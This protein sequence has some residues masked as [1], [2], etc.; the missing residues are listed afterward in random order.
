MNDTGIVKHRPFRK[1]HWVILMV[2]LFAATF[3]VDQGAWYFRTSVIPTTS[4][5]SF[6]GTTLPVLKVANWTALTSEEWDAS[7][8]QLADVGK[9]IPLPTYDPSILKKSTESLGWSSESDLNIRNAKIT[10]S[11]PYMGNYKLD[12]VEY[13]GSHLAVDIK[14]PNNTPIYSIGNGKVVK[15]SKQSS[16]FGKHI[17]ISHY[18]FPALNDAEAKETYYSSYSHLGSVNVVENQV[19][20]KGQYIGKSG[21]T[22]TATTPHLHFQID[23]TNAP[24]HPYWPFTYQESSAADLSFTEAINTGLGKEKALETTI[25]PMLYVQKYMNGF[26]NTTTYTSSNDLPPDDNDSNSSSDDS[27][28]ISDDSDTDNFDLPPIGSNDADAVEDDRAE[29]DNSADV[30]DDV[31]SSN[32]EQTEVYV[33]ADSFEIL[34]DG[35][36][37][38]GVDESIIV[39]AVD[40]RGEVIKNYHPENDI[41]LNVL[42]GSVDAPDN[43][44][45]DDFKEGEAVFTINARASNAIQLEVSDGTTSAQS[46]VMLSEVFSDVNSESK[47]YDAISFLK[48]HEII[49]GYPDGSFK[50][51]NVVSRV[52]SLKFILNGTNSDLITARELPFPDTSARE[53]YSSYVA[54]GYN[55]MI[56]EGYPDSTFKPA[57]T[58]NK[59]E[60]LKMLLIAMNIDINENVRT[61]VYEDVS[62]DEWYAPYVQYGKDK[63]LLII[64]DRKFRPED[65]MTR[66]EVAEL[67]Y[68]TILLKISGA[69]KYSSG[70]RVSDSSVGAYFG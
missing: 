40:E 59:V 16:G 58:V 13:A 64:K 2:L 36:F 34:N 63:N 6:D 28:S 31:A 48:E 52:E 4:P 33:Q 14:L 1:Y 44:D 41:Y 32:E 19:V 47:S 55:R 69:P 25:N 67:M 61:D 68:R 3:L 11:V 60:F 37:M 53:W 39:R 10:Y 35:N 18:N 27:N 21:D 50:P 22:G 12:G 30:A 17:V 51:E 42:L 49:A 5:T 45:K 7:Y 38:V 65:G 29:S 54:T 15:V 62:S 46:K 9:L 70:I 24:W 43:L 26:S 56:V 20:T 8:D 23:N 57:S 66:R